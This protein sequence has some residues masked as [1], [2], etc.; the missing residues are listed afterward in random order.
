MTNTSELA[1]LSLA[2]VLL[3]KLAAKHPNMTLATALE[4]QR[5]MLT[6]ALTEPKSPETI[7]QAAAAI[8]SDINNRDLLPPWN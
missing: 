2:L 4:A 8:Y 5:T 7:E 3:D 6:L 1:R